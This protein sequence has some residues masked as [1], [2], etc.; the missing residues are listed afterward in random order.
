MFSDTVNI[1][2]PSGLHARPASQF[3]R[4]TKQF[5]SSIMIAHSAPDSPRQVNAKSIVALLSLELVQGTNV[6]ITAQGADEEL[7]VT[8]LI[9]LI[10]SGFGE[11]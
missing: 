9:G 3:V 1:K 6:S 11:T 4:A 10:Q 5:E 8:T 2:N 7:A